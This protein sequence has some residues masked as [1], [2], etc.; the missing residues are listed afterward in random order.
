MIKY[1]ANCYRPDYLSV[2]PSTFTLFTGFLPAKII[3]SCQSL[4]PR[5]N[6]FEPVGGHPVS[7]INF[8]QQYKIRKQQGPEYQSHDPEKRQTDKNADNGDQRMRICYPFINDHP[9][10]IIYV[11]NK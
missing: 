4:W 8:E 1:P 5:S 7:F 3:D 2:I 10:E 11:A 9:Q 6:S